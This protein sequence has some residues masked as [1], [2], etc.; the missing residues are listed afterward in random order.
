MNSV[1]EQRRLRLAFEQA[2]AIGALEGGVLTHELAELQEE[3][4]AGVVSFEGAIAKLKSKY[5]HRGA[6]ELATGRASD[7]PTP[8]TVDSDLPSDRV[9]GAKGR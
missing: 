5:D 7:A 2:N 6:V 8:A 3:V 9:A 1:E 4:I